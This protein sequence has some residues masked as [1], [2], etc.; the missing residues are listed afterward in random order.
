MWRRIWEAMATAYYWFSVALA[1]LIALWLELAVPN[2]LR[3]FRDSVTLPNGMVVRREF[4]F[5]FTGRDDLFA[6]DGRTR[7]AWDIEFVCFDDRYVEV[8]ADPGGR[9]GMFDALSVGSWSLRG[10]DRKIA[11]RALTGG[12][13]CNGYYTGMLGASLLYDG[14][15]RPFLPPCDWRNFA[16][17]A[18]RHKE[19][20]LRP[21]DA[22]EIGVSP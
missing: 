20:L 17:P 9:G 3:K 13:G 2:F 8:S 11:E 12:H 22:D 21:C 15:R 6:P 18:L 7:L 4:D 5:T 19:W 14:N 1:V 16:N 10:K